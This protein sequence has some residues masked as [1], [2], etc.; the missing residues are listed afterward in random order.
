MNSR[1]SDTP[2]MTSGLIIGMLFTKVSARFLRPL[3]LW[4]PMAATVPRTIDTKADTSAMSR[5]FSTAEI[6]EALP[7]IR[8][9]NRFSYSFVEN[10]VQLPSTLLSVK[11]NTA[12]NTSG[13]YSRTIRIQ[14]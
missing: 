6:S 14:M 4:M 1:N 5:V 13:A 2:V 3:R 10:P 7:C 8:P 11:E 12:M 9:V